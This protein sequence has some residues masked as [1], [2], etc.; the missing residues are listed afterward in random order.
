MREA[1]IPEASR[2]RE[3]SGPHRARGAKI[4]D[5]EDDDDLR[6]AA[7]TLLRDEGFSVVEAPNGSAALD[8][9]LGTGTKPALILLDLRMPIMSGRQVLHV[10]Q[11]FLR[12][13]TVP[14]VVMTSE[15]LPLEC[16]EGAVARL[17][18]PFTARAL[19]A[20]VRRHARAAAR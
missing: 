11:G 9:L 5:V 6:A 4:L 12:F 19:L 3:A 16:P 1:D 8:Y 13:A 15:S 10:L 18:K 17:Q 14:V 2:S 20:L 7:V